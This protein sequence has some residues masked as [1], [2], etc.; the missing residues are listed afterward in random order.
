[1]PRLSRSEN[2]KFEEAARAGWLYYVAGK[3][4][5]E[6]ARQLSISRQSA[7]RLVALSVS[8]GL[9][10]VRLEHPIAKCMELGARLQ[11]RFNLMACEIVPSDVESP[12]AT[13]GLANKGAVEMERIFK[14]T[15]PKL[16]A[17]GTGR[18][19]RSVAEELSNMNC[20]QH[21]IVS[22]VGNIANDG[23]ATPYDVAVHVAERL[24]CR[25]YPMPLPVISKVESERAQLHAQPHIENVLGLAKQA[26]VS[27]VGIGNLGLK[28]PVF[29]DG[30][31]SEKEVAELDKMGAVGEIIGWIFNKDGHVLQC[32]L[33][34]R[35]LSAPLEL[36]STKP[37]FGIAA[38][39]EK[40]DAILGALRSKLINSL[41]TNEYTAER[42]L[43]S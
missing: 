28:S 11:E 6:I 42:I 16:V 13:V 19:L 20:P 31:V 43:N 39:E 34:K 3:T 1:M 25:Y 17:L 23:F 29:M 37:V 40:V 10:R 33:N 15:E 9:I 21:R 32:D 2:Q 7:Q 8:E 26:D 18:I 36:A 27:F 30:L 22:L 41:I 24:R 12:A 35:V 14:A 4:Q 5:D 38:G